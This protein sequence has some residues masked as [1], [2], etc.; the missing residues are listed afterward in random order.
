MN[1][2]IGE[3]RQLSDLARELTISKNGWLCPT[4]V[5]SPLLCVSSQAKELSAKIRRAWLKS[6]NLD[7]RGEWLE[8]YSDIEAS[9]LREQF[10]EL[11][12]RLGSLSS[13]VHERVYLRAL[14]TRVNQFRR[15]TSATTRAQEIVNDMIRRFSAKNSIG[16]SRTPSLKK[17]AKRTKSVIDWAR[18]CTEAHVL[19]ETDVELVVL[20]RE[21]QKFAG[22]PDGGEDTDG[23]VR[24]LE[25]TW[26]AVQLEGRLRKALLVLWQWYGEAD[27]FDLFVVMGEAYQLG[28]L[29]DANTYYQAKELLDSAPAE[30]A[31][32]TPQQSLAELADERGRT[33]QLQRKELA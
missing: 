14:S 20:L 23:K 33:V 17:F 13:S 31:N 9:R 24:R 32:L 19:V 15:G 6:V 26:S 28:G 22:N 4:E 1:R 25:L 2:L 21:L 30:P 11:W 10:L 8:S 5:L 16:E 7:R 27:K 18:R 29:I 3:M 12:D